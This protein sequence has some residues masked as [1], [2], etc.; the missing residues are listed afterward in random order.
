M[1]FILQRIAPVTTGKSKERWSQISNASMLTLREII[2][3]GQFKSDS[4]GL[5][6]KPNFLFSDSIKEDKAALYYGDYKWLR[7]IGNRRFFPPNVERI[8]P[9]LSAVYVCVSDNGLGVGQTILRSYSGQD[10]C[11]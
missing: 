10:R 11:P 3:D 6:R 7:Q 4:R 2:F 8:S 1:I 5:L 9:G